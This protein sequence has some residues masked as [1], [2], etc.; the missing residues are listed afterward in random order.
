[1]SLQVA[2]ENLQQLLRATYAKSILCSA[3]FSISAEERVIYHKILA[4]QADGAD[5][6]RSLRKFNLLFVSSL[7][8]KNLG[9]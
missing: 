5:L 3:G 1:M 6:R 2:T 9:F 7:W 8:S 4:K